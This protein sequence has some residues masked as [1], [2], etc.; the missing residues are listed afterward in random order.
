MQPLLLHGLAVHQ[1]SVAALQI[2]NLKSSIFRPQQTVFSRHRRIS[3][4]YPVR[5]LATKSDFPVSQRKDGIL[6][7]TCYRQQSRVHRDLELRAPFLTTEWLEMHS[8][9]NLVPI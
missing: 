5:G 2:P 4:W 8:Q 6:Y 3:N 1:G 7:G 9:L